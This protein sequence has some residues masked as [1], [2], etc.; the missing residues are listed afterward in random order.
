MKSV[1]VFFDLTTAFETIR[2]EDVWAAGFRARFLAAML[3]LAMESFAFARRLTF[4][5]EIAEPFHTLSAI[6]AGSGMAKI[7]L[8]IVLA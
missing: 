6:L 8:A 2:L 7:A 5:K 4:R 1:A 3:R